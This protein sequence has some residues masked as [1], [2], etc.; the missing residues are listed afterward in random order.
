MLDIR[1]LFPTF[2]HV[3]YPENSATRDLLFAHGHRLIEARQKGEI[4]AM[5][6]IGSIAKRS[7]PVVVLV[8]AAIQLVPV[9]RTNPSI[10]TELS[11]PPEVRTVLK[12]ACYD[13]HSNET[14]WPWY[15]RVAPVS[16][17]I[18]LDVRNGRKE[19]NFSTWNRT[20]AIKRVKLMRKCWEEVHEGEMPPWFYLL[21]HPRARLTDGDRGLLRDWALT[22]GGASTIDHVSTR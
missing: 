4:T 2:C 9:N 1:I 17:L 5:R 21:L 3:P 15:S 10:E 18:A 14:V 13:C 7:F 12:R 8:F 20:T 11:T 22:G 6:N 19:M 16:W